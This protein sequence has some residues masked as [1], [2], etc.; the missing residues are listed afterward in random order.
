[1]CGRGNLEFKQEIL[2]RFFYTMKKNIGAT[3]RL[4]IGNLIK[5]VFD[6]SGL[7][8]SEFAR[9][10]HCERTN[11]YAI[12][13]RM[14]IDVE[15]LIQISKVLNHNFFDDILLFYNLKSSLCPSQITMTF[16][17]PI[18]DAVQA[19]QLTQLLKVLAPL[20]H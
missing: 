4:H 8:V 19:E 10:I 18:P 6:E 15:Q 1:M 3:D 5:N 14:S 16:N 9:R 7:S 11:V 2:P 17:V 20:K 12:F 13:A